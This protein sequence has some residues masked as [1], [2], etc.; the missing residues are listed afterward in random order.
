[1]QA[2]AIGDAQDSANAEQRAARDQ[3]Q[4]NL[5]PYMT[6]GTNALAPTQALLGLS[7]QD[8]A[9]AAMA[10]FQKSP[11]YD[12]QFNEGMRAVESSAA[13]QGMLHSGA[14]LKAL[15][16]RGQQLG[17]ASF[18][19]YYNRLLQVVGLG[20]NAAAGVGNTGVQTARDIAQTDASAASGMGSIYG[21]AA[22]GL[23]NAA[24]TYANNSIHGD[25]K[26]NALMQPGTVTISRAGSGG[27]PSYETLTS[28][29]S[30]G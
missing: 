13:A 8:A 1:M 10:N 24:N 5:A 6:A 26:R 22:Q 7:G 21:N 17:N 16:A 14:T 23:G 19:Q 15:Q 28:G 9:N 30:G 11:A 27:Y 4:A 3:A 2:D 18:D 12:F 20:Q 29:W 25:A